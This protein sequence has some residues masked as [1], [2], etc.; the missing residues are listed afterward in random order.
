MNKNIVC[1][2]LLELAILLFIVTFALEFLILFRPLYYFNITYMRM[3]PATNYSYTEIKQGFDELM[4]FLVFYKD[5]KMG[6]F[7][8]SNDAKTHFYDCRNLFTLNFVVLILS[9]ITLITLYI[10]NKKNIIAIRYKRLSMG[11]SSIFVFLVVFVISIICS[12]INFTKFF[13]FL[14]S[15]FFPGKNNFM[16]TYDDTIIK[17][18]PEELWINYGIAL[19]VILLIFNIAIIINFIKTKKKKINE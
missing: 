3:P 11:M 12:L 15:I 16:F 1:K 8:C 14:H 9:T 6:I 4:D 19:I 13:I 7:V 5:F 17:I 2:V 18:L 10:L